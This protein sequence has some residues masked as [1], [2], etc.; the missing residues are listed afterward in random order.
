MILFA[1]LQCQLEP[2]GAMVEHGWRLP[3]GE[4]LTPDN[5]TNQI[6]VSE[7]GTSQ[8][9][10]NVNISV[11][12]IIINQLSYQHAGVYSC[13]VQNTTTPGAE[14]VT[15]QVELQLRGITRSAQCAVLHSCPYNP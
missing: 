12:V 4:F 3:S 5:D 9:S 2:F 14:W 15:A 8:M 11:L 6:Q 10:N 1:F 7:I 13:E